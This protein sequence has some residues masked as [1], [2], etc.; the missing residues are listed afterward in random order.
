MIRK[1]NFIAHLLIRLKLKENHFYLRGRGRLKK[2]DRSDKE[3][4]FQ[5]KAKKHYSIYHIVVISVKVIYHFNR[6]YL[7]YGNNLMDAVGLMEG[8]LNWWEIFLKLDNLARNQISL[9]L[10]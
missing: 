5:L 8:Q 6:F 9:N 2:E 10:L 7:A 4:L 3:T 1:N